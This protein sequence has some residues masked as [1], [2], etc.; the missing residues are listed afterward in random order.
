MKVRVLG[1]SGA[2]A[3]GC[4]TTAFLLDHDVLVDAGTGVGDLPLAEMACVDHVCLTHSHWDH[5]AALP[6]MIDAVGGARSRP[7]RVYALAE[8][9]EALRVHVF[10]DVLWPDFC[11]IPS[12]DQPYVELHPIQMGDV[13]ELGGK[14]LVVLPA[15][16]TVPAVG[17]AVTGGNP[18]GPAWVFSGD[19]SHNPGFW[20]RVNA[21]NVGALV[22]ETAFSEKEKPLAHISKHLCPSG[23]G[24]ELAMMRPESHFPI[25]ITHTKPAETAQIMSEIGQINAKRADRDLSPYDIR[26]LEAGQEL[27]L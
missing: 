18:D 24:A 6:L 13:L 4:R 5:I 3:Q 17:Y 16:H 21:M 1:C 26:W 14:Q 7:L 15:E 19:T 10:N 9:I 22:I 8:T 20:Q 12:P 11:R 2:I 27:V 23:L 25:Y